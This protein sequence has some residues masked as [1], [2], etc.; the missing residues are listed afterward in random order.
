MTANKLLS[1]LRHTQGLS[2]IYLIWLLGL[3]KLTHGP[4]QTLRPY[5][6]SNIFGHVLPLFSLNSLNNLIGRNNWHC[7]TVEDQGCLEW[8]YFP[9]GN[10]AYICLIQWPPSL[11][12]I[13]LTIW[14]RVSRAAT[15]EQLYPEPSDDNGKRGRKRKR[16][17]PLKEKI[18]LCL[19]EATFMNKAPTEMKGPHSLADVPLSGRHPQRGHLWESSLWNVW[20]IGSNPGY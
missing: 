14:R 5:L 19:A 7:L 13:S 6:A 17:S 9:P 20:D 3:Q 15:L 18:S 16:S 8:K 2:E 10:K 1:F 4:W 11:P 12:Y